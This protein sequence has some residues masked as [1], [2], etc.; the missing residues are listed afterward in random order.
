MLQVLC[1]PQWALDRLERAMMC[2]L[3]T[4]RIATGLNIAFLTILFW[5]SVQPFLYTCLKF[6]EDLFTNRDDK[7]CS[8]YNVVISL[9]PENI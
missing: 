4:N 9:L 3:L 1:K 8:P 2:A 7:S 5:H 6:L